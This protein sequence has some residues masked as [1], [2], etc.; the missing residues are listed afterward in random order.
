MYVRPWPM[1][2]FIIFHFY[3]AE[4]V[5]SINYMCRERERGHFMYANF[6]DDTNRLNTLLI[7]VVD[8]AKVQ[9]GKP[10]SRLFQ[11]QLEIQPHM[12]HSLNYCGKRRQP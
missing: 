2:G 7:L 9:L 8:D 1:A 12:A 6:W 11:F 5:I 3:L 4:K 10:R